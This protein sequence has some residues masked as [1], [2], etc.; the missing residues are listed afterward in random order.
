MIDLEEKKQILNA[1]LDEKIKRS[2][3]L[4][5][6]WY[7]Q[8]DGNIYV[9]FSGG[10]DST[11]LLHLVRSLYPDVPAVYANTGL[12]YPEINQFVKTIENVTILKPK[13]SFKK[14]L[15]KYGYPVISKEQSQFI[16]EY[17]TTESQKL[18]DIRE[19]GNKWGMGK[20]SERWKFMIDAPFKITS[21]CCDTF[22]KD[23]F[24]KYEK[25]TGRKGMVGVMAGESKLRSQYYFKTECN[26][27]HSKRPMSRPLFFWNETDIW[28]YIR[29]FEVE[30]SKIYDMGYE[31]TG[32]MFCA[33]GL[34]NE[35]ESGEETRFERMKKTHPKLYDYCMDKLGMRKVLEYYLKNSKKKNK[36]LDMFD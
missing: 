32:C 3:M 25:D 17:R 35:F 16:S 7:A 15:E 13:M 34:H 11:V 14:A 31:R 9:S 27:F 30:Y 22:K 12:E 29:D 5:M 1:P 20:I 18:K 24:K 28:K 21:K 10:K 36:Q 33:Y 26:A 8:F 19:N 4:I 6:D 23:P 2:K